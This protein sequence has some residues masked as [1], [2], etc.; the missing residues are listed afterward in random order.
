MKKLTLGVCAILMLTTQLKAQQQPSVSVT[1]SG[2]GK[3]VTTTSSSSY[4]YTNIDV[5][6]SVNVRYGD[7]TQEVQDET[8]MKAKSFTKS[9]SIDKNDKINLSNQFGT[10]TIKTWDKNEIKVDAD[11]KAY[12]KTADEAQK[13]IDDVSISATKTGDLVSYKTE[14]GDRNSNWGSSVKN[15][16]TIWRREVK[17][18]YTVYMP[19]YNA[20]NASQQ[21]GNISMGDF[22]GPTSIKVQYGNFNAGNLSNINNYV[23]VQYGDANIQELNKGV[24]KQQY[25]KVLTI[26]TIGTLDLNVQYAGANIGSV[27]G[28]AIIKKQ[29]GGSLVIGSVDN[30]D[31]DA[32]YTNVNITTVNGNALIKQQYNKLTLGTVGKLKLDAQYVGTIIGSLKGDGAFDTEYNSLTIGNVHSACKILTVKAQYAELNIGFTDAYNANFEVVKTY[33]GFKY[34]DNVTSRMTSEDSQTKRYSGKIGNGG[35]ATVKITSE[36]NSVT[37]K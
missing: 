10:I 5:K 14:T 33:G 37:F 34:G 17:V 12:A 20:L 29:Y 6:N 19:A 32:Q 2:N 24:V 7:K 18:Y 22:S 27:K 21:Y 9:F 8:P 4:A 25:G 35:T 15:G 1:T 23:N 28:N 11:I 31:L 13:L 26:G 30:L 36:Y 16:K 3:S